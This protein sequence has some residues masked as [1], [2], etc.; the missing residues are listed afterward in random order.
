MVT[1]T[2]RPWYQA[3]IYVLCGLHRSLVPSAHD[4]NF[5][6]KKRNAQVWGGLLKQRQRLVC[7]NRY[8]QNVNQFPVILTRTLVTRTR[9]MTRTLVTRTRT[10]TRTL[11]SRTRT[12]TRTLVA[13]T[14]TR[15]LVSRSKPVILT[16]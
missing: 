12:R 3:K 7:C 5:Q 13:R 9:T 14:R 11:V 8:V 2:L 6:Q 1:L 16:L 4:D 15:T 10:R